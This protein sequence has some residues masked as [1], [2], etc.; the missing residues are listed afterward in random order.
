MRRAVARKAYDEAVSAAWK[1]FDKATAEAAL[2]VYAEAIAPAARKAYDEAF[3]EAIAPAEK[4]YGEAMAAAK[5]DFDEAT[6]AAARKY[7]NP[8]LLGRILLGRIKG[9]FRKKKEVFQSKE[10]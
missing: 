5:K 9:H 10:I 4:V 2:K 8:G 6:A 1:A 3:D 7:S